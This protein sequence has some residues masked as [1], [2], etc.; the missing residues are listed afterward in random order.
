[1]ESHR[2][3]ELLD[4]IAEAFLDAVCQFCDHP[5]LQYRWPRYIPLKVSN[6]FWA[7]LKDEIHELLEE[8]AVL[9]GN[10]H[11]PLRPIHQLKQIPDIFKD[12]YGNPLVADLDEEMYLASEYQTE[13]V[14]ALNYLGLGVLG[15]GN[16]TQRFRHDLK[17]PSSRSR[18][19]SPETNDDWHTR[20]AKLLLLP[21]EMKMYSTIIDA[22]RRLACI[23]LQNGKWI[24]ITEGA[25]F[26]PHTEGIRIPTDLGL[27]I[28]D[29]K[30]ITNPTRKKFFLTLGVKA[31]SIQTIRALIL[32]R[33][34][35]E[36]SSIDF[37]TS[38]KDL[39][40]LYLTHSPGTTVKL[41]DSTSLWVF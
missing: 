28:V 16:I 36:S 35:Q 24:A 2:N 4:G 15:F 20:T 26:F 37:E 10:S 32:G 11:G 29:E 39:N 3:K 14:A 30:S 1:M 33:Y 18:F 12:G 21:F 27:N 9:R 34:S 25:V 22:I 41:R 5:T 38:L 8:R 17:Q 6:P 31:A 40:F 23:P 19:K 13:D 7:R